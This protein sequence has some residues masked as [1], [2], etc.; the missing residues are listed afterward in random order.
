MKREDRQKLRDA[1]TTA[2]AAT[3]PYTSVAR[4]LDRWELQTSNSFRR[5][6]CHGDGDVLCGTKQPHD[7][8]PDLRAPHGV[9]DY[10]VA[11][12]PRTVLVLLDALDSAETRLET[13]KALLET[14]KALDDKIAAVDKKLA[15]VAFV[16]AAIGAA[17][18][19]LSDPNSPIEAVADAHALI[20]QLTSKLR[21]AHT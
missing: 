1:A 17:A 12:Q 11:A 10:I 6:G 7:G 20:A 15:S 8:H 4:V 3:P 18:A 19:T 13:A 2:I 14:A 16:V 21:E 9:L 5:I